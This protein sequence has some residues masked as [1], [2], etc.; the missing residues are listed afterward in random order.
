MN[1]LLEHIQTT[2]KALPINSIAED[3]K[4]TLLPLIQYIQHKVHNNEAVLLHFICT[5]NSRRSHLAQVWAQTMAY[6]FNVKQVI[7]YS[8]GTEVT[9]VYPKIM[10]TLQQQGFIIE[11]LATSNNLVYAIKYAHNAH[12]IIAFSKKI[13]DGFFNPTN[14]F[15]AI[16]TCNSAA[17]ACP[18]VQGAT[19]RIAITYEDPKVYDNTKQQAEKYLERSV[20]IATE[21][22]YV[23]SNIVTH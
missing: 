3:R 23:F 8:G 13:A 1:I 16:M 11:P 20:Q 4:R 9:A 10:E 21:M 15:A 18:I 22:L 12:P 6:A 2:I 7:C 5:H 14:A 19:E 17:E